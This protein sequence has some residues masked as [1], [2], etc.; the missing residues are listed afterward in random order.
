MKPTYRNLGGCGGGGTPT[1]SNP[2]GVRYLVV[3]G[4]GKVVDAYATKE[5]AIR[6]CD[7]Y[8]RVCGGVYRVVAVE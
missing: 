1:L 5:E 4:K 3:V 7:R 8:R 2:S 6:S